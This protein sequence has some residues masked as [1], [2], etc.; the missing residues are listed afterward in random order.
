MTIHIQ[1]KGEVYLTSL[2][3]RERYMPPTEA[4]IKR[5]MVDL[6][7]ND[8]IHPILV[9]VVTGNDKRSAINRLVTGACRFEAAKRLGWK[10][11][12]AE[13]VTADHELD[14]KMLEIR[15]NLYR[16]GL[17]AQQRREMKAKLVEYQKLILAD[18]RPGDPGR[19]N[20]GGLSK[21]ARDAGISRTTAQRRQKSAHNMQSGQISVEQDD[22]LPYPTHVT[23]PNNDASDVDT[24]PKSNGSYS[25]LELKT[26]PFR[27][28]VAELERLEKFWPG[29]YPNRGEC[30]RDLVRQACKDI[31]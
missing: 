14:Y 7:K 15:E 23:L 21:A 16:R 29:K 24:P 12:R 6:K 30:V 27:C 9:R 19:G 26:V 11:L 28:T 4:D 8:Q 18:V 22:G 25:K 5:M 31:Q 1:K 20:K 10:S 13:Y 2:I 3:V 17:T